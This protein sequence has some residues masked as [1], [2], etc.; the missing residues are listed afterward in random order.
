MWMA[1]A[2]LWIS[3]A[4][5]DFTLLVRIP[6]AWYGDNMDSLPAKLDPIAEIAELL[7]EQAEAS[8]STAPTDDN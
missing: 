3:N 6:S 2:R 4:R 7:I 8:L 5:A 1:S